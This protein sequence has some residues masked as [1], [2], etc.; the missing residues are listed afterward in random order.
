MYDYKSLRK[1]I[2]LLAVLFGV[3]LVVSVVTSQPLNKFAW[4]SVLLLAVVGVYFVTIPLKLLKEMAD[5]E[6]LVEK[7]K[8]GARKSND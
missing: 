5:M 1:I 8:N 3:V 4:L 6:R 7:Y 2:T